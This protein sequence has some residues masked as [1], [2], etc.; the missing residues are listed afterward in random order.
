MEDSNPIKF[1]KFLNLRV[2]HKDF[3]NAFKQSWDENIYG[4]PLWILHQKLTKTSKA[5][6][7]CSKATF[8]DIF[9][10]VDKLESK[11]AQLENKFLTDTYCDNR[12]LLNQ[13]NAH[14]ILALKRKESLLRQK[15]RVKWFAEGDANSS[16]FNNTIKGRKKKLV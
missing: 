5:L 9:E 7:I 8:G 15:A 4:N 11:V 14:Y 2:D 12:A 13:A 10:K 16:Y 3:I 6:N 1:F